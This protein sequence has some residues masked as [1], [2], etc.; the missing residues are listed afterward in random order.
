MRRPSGKDIP[1]LL[2]EL[3]LKDN[4]RCIFISFSKRYSQILVTAADL[5]IP[6]LDSLNK[7]VSKVMTTISMCLAVTRAS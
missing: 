6:D 3:H 4:L 1:K 2:L 5:N 7:C